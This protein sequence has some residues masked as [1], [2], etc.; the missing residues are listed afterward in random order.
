MQ[1]GRPVAVLEAHA[2][3]AI[4]SPAAIC[5]PFIEVFQGIEAEMTI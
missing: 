5:L 1:M 4:T 2:E 3:L